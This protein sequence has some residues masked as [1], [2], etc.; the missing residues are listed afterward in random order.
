ML[1][2][3]ADKRDFERSPEPRPGAPSRTRRGPPI[4][5]VQ[6]HDATRLHYDLRLEVGGVLASWAVPKG[7]S[8]DPRDKRLAVRVEDHPL[9]YAEFEGVIPAGYGAGTVLLWDR[10]AF[11][12]EGDAA[13]GLAAGMLKF[14]LAGERLRGRWML[15]RTKGKEKPRATPQETWLLVKE[16]D[17]EA[18][19]GWSPEAFTT[20]VASGRTMAEIAAG[21]PPAPAVASKPPPGQR[22]GAA[23]RAAAMPRS[24]KPQL[25]THADAA[26]AGD[27]WLHEVKFDGYRL[28]AWVTAEGTRLISRSGKDWTAKLP[29]L[30]R[31]ISERC[32]GEAI[33]DGEAVVLDG[34]G[35]SDFQALQN[36]IGSARGAQV[37]FMAFDL[38]WAD[39]RDLTRERLLD[40]K[41]LLA[42]LLGPRQHGRVRLSE[43]AVGEGPAA[44]ARACEHGL[45]GVVS[46]RADAPYVQGRSPAWLKV[47]CFDQQEFVVAGWTPPEGAREEFGALVLGVH[48]DAGRLT[49]A[50]RVG[51]GFSVE[52]LR[53]L[54]AALRRAAAPRHPFAS[55]P[56]DPEL[57][58]ATWVKP[59][60]VAQVRFQSWTRDGT[61][62]FPTFRGLREDIDPATVTRQ[63]TTAA[64]ARAGTTAPPAAAAATSAE[65]SEP[66][67]ASVLRS[68]ARGRRGRAGPAAAA[69]VADASSK[70]AARPRLT[71]PTREVFPD[72]G[73]GYRVTKAQV[74]AYYEAVAER[75]LAE[76]R[77]R[78][79]AI[80][81]CPKGEGGPCFFQKHLAKGMPPG[82]VGVPT[83]EGEVHL[84]ISGAEGLLG[85]V[86]LNALEFHPWGCRA[87]D[88]EH[89]DRLV[90]DFDPG[91]GV[92]WGELAK[93]ALL[94]RNSLAEV[95]LTAFVRTSGGRGLHVVVPLLREHGWEEVSGFAR[96]VAQTLV[97]MRPRLFVAVAD[98]ERRRGRI[99]LDHLRNARGAT[100]VASYSTRA[101]PGGPVAM[102]LAWSELESGVDPAAFHVLTVARVLQ[103][104]PDPWS[105]LAA[106]AGRLPRARGTR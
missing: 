60:L 27:G 98:K 51:S 41:G 50:G 84:S 100:A 45:E 78:P 11:E 32:P 59:A 5:A 37:V 28:L 14:R 55:L 36:A 71:S 67:A 106:A 13:E 29:H 35:V 93:A 43:H 3:Y 33:L 4:F 85:L 89:P 39:G 88:V 58:K 19:P 57:R 83:G 65:A 44:F 69:P 87:E 17:A 25:A 49:Y 81:R 104:R 42:D 48:D 61:L 54:G 82:V 34:R 38:P 8:L 15:V 20:S 30:A 46:K 16:R 74:A 94:L 24:I 75:M 73:A 18:A 7:P 95:G 90:F 77:G 76:L 47:K 91:P 56:A 9:A 97:A 12:P 21:A 63:P 22:V 102:P 105:G 64:T 6:K 31:A 99:Y 23:G 70:V 79:L 103:D 80:V 101:R 10:G 92:D 2:T 1:K 40:R 68:A 53:V 62:R 96:A 66:A 26:P 72:R 86:Q 52:T